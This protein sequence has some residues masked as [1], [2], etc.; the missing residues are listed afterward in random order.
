MKMT[1]F[2]VIQ[3]VFNALLVVA[4]VLNL[5]VMFGL[6]ERWVSFV[7]FVLAIGGCLMTNSAT[8]GRQQ[9]QRQTVSGNPVLAGLTYITGA[10]WL[11]TFAVIQ[12][13]LVNANMNQ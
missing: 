12:F 3:L 4:T 10:A 9:G 1:K 13:G 8:G 5:L 2:D 6:C 7:G 11:I